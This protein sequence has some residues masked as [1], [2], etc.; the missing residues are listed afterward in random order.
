MV[1][2]LGFRVRLEL[3]AGNSLTGNVN[4]VAD[5]VLTL[6]TVEFSDGTKKSN[7]KIAGSEI[8]DLKVLDLPK[9]LQKSKGK[10]KNNTQ[11]PSTVVYSSNAPGTPGTP[12]S[13]SSQQHKGAKQKGN[14]KRN[15][16]AGYME[17][18]S[19][20]NA[21]AVKSSGDFDFSGQTAAFDKNSALEEFA[22]R[23]NID[24]SQRLVGLNKKKTKYE[25]DENV[26]ASNRK[27]GWEDQ[28]HDSSS[29][30][31]PRGTEVA[32]RKLAEVLQEKIPAQASKKAPRSP[33]VAGSIY[34]FASVSGEPLPLVTPV[35]LVEVERLTNENFKLTPR[36]L[37]ENCS[38]GVA[39]IIIKMLGGHSRLAKS[40]HNLPPL[41][42][43]LVGNNRAGARALA[44]GR[45]L[46]NHGVRAIAFTITN[47][48][49]PDEFEDHTA[50][51]LELFTLCGGK[52]VSE[53]KQLTSVL[54]SIETP[55]EL[56]L[57]ALQGYD[58]RIPDLWGEELQKAND[59]ITW[60]NKTS[61]VNA[62]VSLDI[63]AGID[64]GSGLAEE[65]YL[66]A[67]F[68]VSTGLPLSGLELAYGN[69]IVSKG[70][71]THHLVDIGI[72]QKL[73]KKGNLRKFDR[74]WFNGQFVVSMDLVEK[75]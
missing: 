35:S 12:G 45:Q 37:A 64:A 61:G 15:Q 54:G 48:T 36:I 19:W 72:P 7:W 33:S 27:D 46:A 5:K 17:E 16:S 44:A 9:E 18:P 66:N 47:H 57:D 29:S 74:S 70:D 8:L 55:V 13:V 32:S 69:G 51:Q 50:H 67:K 71:W 24:E 60:V 63:P 59:I 75:T 1:S 23:D 20:G 68:V 39:S 4:N 2:V 10:K 56:I 3:K 73:F 53:M 11:N 65:N 43:L 6:D 52:C 21:D 38:R 42:L 14:Q 62:V 25:H 49:K 41:V 28:V 40:N 58:T 31:V 34:Q 22:V 26:L 30:S